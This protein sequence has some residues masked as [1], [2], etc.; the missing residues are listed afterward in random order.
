L[1]VT[2]RVGSL[3]TKIFK[4]DKQ[5]DKHLVSFSKNDNQKFHILPILL[6]N[7]GAF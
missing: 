3:S 6:D 1:K 5:I 4:G 7:S 2:N